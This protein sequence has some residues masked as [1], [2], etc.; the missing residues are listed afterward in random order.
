[1]A[2]ITAQEH[3]ALSIAE[4]HRSKSVAHAVF[5][6]HAADNARCLFKVAISARSDFT[7]K[8]FLGNTSCK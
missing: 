8:N 5:H 6:N 2:Q 7:N 3:L 1:M 4:L